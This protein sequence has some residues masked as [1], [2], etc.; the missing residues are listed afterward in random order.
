MAEKVVRYGMIGCGEI[1]VQ[2]FKAVMEAENAELAATYD[3]KEDL[4]KDLA[5]QAEGAEPCGTQKDLLART[6][7]DA[8]LIS[9]PHYLHEPIAVAAMEAGK[10]VLCEKPIACTVAQGQ[11]IV[12]VAAETGRK[13][14]CCFVRRYGSDTTGVRKVVTDGTLGKVTAWVIMGLANK[15]E[16][17]WTGGYTQRAKTDWRLKRETAGGGFLIMNSIHTIDWMRYV[18]DQEV[19]SAKAFGGTFNS[20]EGVEVEDL[21]SGVVSLS[22]GG[23]GVI[24]GG[25]AVPG[26]GLGETRIVGTVGQ[27]TFGRRGAT[28]IYLTEGGTVAGQEIPAK[29][30]TEIDL[31]E[32]SEGGSRS[33]MVAAFGRWVTDGEPFRSPGDDALK[34]LAV[35]ESIYRDAGLT[36]D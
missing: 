8:V 13:L 28:Q 14:G 17:Y 22:G 15:K 25:S 18:T 24:T 3:V 29:E 9:T 35:C 5:E 10:H 7:V 6:D 26:A 33:A 31:S 1:A 27:M 2:N 20:P 23:L 21:I 16:S 12:D 32:E 19:V 11:H 4:A 30:W 36:V 34:T